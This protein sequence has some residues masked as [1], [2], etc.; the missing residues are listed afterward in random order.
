MKKL[1]LL[2]LLLNALQASF[3]DYN[4]SR[5]N[6]EVLKNLDIESSFIRDYKLQKDYQYYQKIQNPKHHVS[7]LNEASLFI[8]RVKDILKQKGIPDLFL[9]MAMV[10]S[11]FSI[12]A[13]SHV[14]ATGLWQFMDITANKYGLKKD[15]Y[16]DERMDLVKSTVAAAKYLNFLYDEFGKW[17]LAV[18]AYNCGEGRV[19]EALTRSILDIYVNQNP[20]EKNSKKIRK[21]RNTIKAYQKKKAKFYELGKIYQEVSMW[22]IEP[23]LSYLLKEQRGID[24]QYLPKESRRYIRKILALAMLNYQGFIT[25]STK[26][27]HF[28]NMGV[29]TTIATV[30]VKGGLHLKNIAKALNMTYEELYTLNKHIR[31]GITPPYEAFYT[32]NIPYNKLAKYNENKNSIPNTKFAI[33]VVK[34]GDSLSSISKKY[35]VPLSTIKKYNRL[36]TNL[37]SLRQKIILPI[38]SNKLGKINLFN[39]KKSG[40]TKKHIVKSG[41]SLY[42]IS[43]KYKVDIRNLMEKNRMKTTLLKIGDRIVIR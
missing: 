24:R 7:N 40:I 6:I 39:Y 30:P 36:K 21:F 1:I 20:S 2:V 3:L 25:N 43:K 42:S 35:K 14:K 18:L 17:Y 9:Y 41:D 10:E 33:H 27:S 13:K 12:D 31:Q 19:I 5:G 28:I 26:N 23:E 16:I 37:L 38:S 32:I 15:I 11:N 29:S 22:G 4:F 8:P 34:S